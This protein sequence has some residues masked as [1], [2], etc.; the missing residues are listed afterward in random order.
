MRT[1]KDPK[2]RR[3]EILNIAQKL[4]YTKGYDKSTINDI[5]EAAGIAKGTFYYYFKSKEEVMDA[6]IK[7]I[8]DDIIESAEII[9]KD[10]KMTAEEKLCK[11]IMRQSPDVKKTDEVL[12]ELHQVE[13]AQLHQKSIV[14]TILRLTPILA[15][16]IEQGIDE[17]VF[18]TPYPK[19]S[20]ECLLVSS[21]FLF[22]ESIFHFETDEL[23]KKV[24]AYI[25]MMEKT[26]GAQD[27]SLS[28]ITKLFK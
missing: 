4:F 2:E 18:K 23:E 15:E 16:V 20:I 11:I 14:E 10:T 8:V 17:G 5:L 26:L 27:G 12:E 3:N 19:E 25:Y 21:Q 1:L 22:D 13:N 24:K 9:A 28:Y 7:R 6:I